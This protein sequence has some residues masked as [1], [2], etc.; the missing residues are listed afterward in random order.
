MKSGGQGFDGKGV[1][2]KVTC[3]L[4]DLSLPS[5]IS[6]FFLPAGLSGSAC[7]SVTC[8]AQGARHEKRMGK[9]LKTQEA[10]HDQ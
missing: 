5:S 3:S 7:G 10:R 1:W 2:M 8:T 6:G 4:T 9:P